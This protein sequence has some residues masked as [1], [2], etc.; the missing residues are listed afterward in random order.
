MDTGIQFSRDSWGNL[1]TDGLISA[2][3]FQKI[4]VFTT[5]TSTYYPVDHFEGT[6]SV[7]VTDSNT[8]FNWL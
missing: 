8:T 3:L 1:V 6:V 5:V 4:P 7:P 2:F